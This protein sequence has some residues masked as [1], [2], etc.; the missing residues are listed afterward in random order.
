MAYELPEPIV[1]RRQKGRRDIRTYT[2][3]A[4]DIAE[5]I[6]EGMAQHLYVGGRPGHKNKIEIRDLPRGWTIEVETYNTD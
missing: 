1:T 6:A 4:D 2:L 5:L 3:R